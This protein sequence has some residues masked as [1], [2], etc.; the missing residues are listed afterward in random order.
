[1]SAQKQPVSGNPSVRPGA[2][3]QPLNRQEFWLDTCREVA[4]MHIRSNPVLE[5]YRRFGCR[6]CLPTHEQVQSVLAALDSAM[7]NWE[8]LHPQLFYQ[9]L[10]LNYPDLVR[11]A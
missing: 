4:Q 10:E 1:M 2:D 5:L 6:F 3:A 7:P 11:R 8:K 9:T